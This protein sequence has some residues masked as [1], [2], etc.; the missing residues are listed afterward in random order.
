MAS[1]PTVRFIL[2]SASPRRRQLMA[3]TGWGFSAM[4]APVDESPLAGEAPQTLAD[5]LAR[6][7]AQSAQGAASNGSWILAAD[8]LVV[9]RGVVLGKPGD[10]REALDMLDTLRGRTHQVITSL[11]L[12]DPASGEVHSETCRSE[13]SMR[14]YSPEEARAFVARGEAWDKAGGYAIQDPAF[15]PVDRQRM[16]DCF[17]NVVGLPLCH[18]VRAMRRA[19]LEPPQDVPQACQAH[20]DYRCPVYQDILEG[21][22]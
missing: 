2:A 3:L 19:G 12:I 7:K 4:E 14:D 17:A 13:V 20:T 22:R 10:E 21:R 1:T 16:R 5:R 8:T 18:L 15:H 9:D 11:A 6:S